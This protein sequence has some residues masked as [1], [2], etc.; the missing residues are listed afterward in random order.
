MTKPHQSRSNPFF[1]IAMGLAGIKL[2]KIHSKHKRSFDHATKFN[3]ITNATCHNESELIKH[4]H[5]FDNSTKFNN[6]TN[7]TCHNESELSPLPGET[8]SL[9]DNSE[10]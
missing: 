9:V 6:I 1:I 10:L 4:K 7:A 2:L 5:S 8:N 3:N